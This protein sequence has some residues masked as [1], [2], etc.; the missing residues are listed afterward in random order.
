[1]TSISNQTVT[2]ALYQKQ[3]DLNSQSNEIHSSNTE[4]QQQQD[5]ENIITS[6][7]KTLIVLT[8]KLLFMV[9]IPCLCQATT[10]A[11]LHPVVLVPGSG[12]NQIE[13]RLT[14][15]YKPSSLVCALSALRPKG[16]WFRLWFQPSVIVAPLTQCFAERMMLYY[17]DELDDYH[18]APG[19]ETRVPFFG[20][21]EGL[22]YLDPHLKH[23]TEYMATLVN[24]MERI[25]YESGNNLFGAPYDF[26]YGLAAEG[27]PCHVGNQYLQ[28]LKQLIESAF[29]SNGEKPVIILSHSLGGLFVLQ[30]LNRSPL[31]WRQKY[32]KHFIA[33][34]APWGGAVL[35]MLTFASGYTL[36]IPIVN[37]LIVR[38]EQRSSESNLWLM[39]SPKFFAEKP[40][41]I[42]EKKN[43]SACD[44][45]EFLE[46]IGFGEGVHPYKTRIAPLLYSLEA[47]GVPVT[48][49]VGSGVVT[50]ETLLYG[51]EGFDVQPEIVYGDGDGTVNM[52][53]LLALES[54]WSSQEGQQV[55]NVIKV[56]GVSHMSLLK[57][58]AAVKEIIA[59][60][61]SI[62]SIH[63][64]SVS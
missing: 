63:L 20:S 64:T 56:S 28:D 34:S 1:M 54:E 62:N 10:G 45:Q 55:L 30:L 52:A 11:D 3:S 50:P 24:S 36:G 48:C 51:K 60:V 14:S 59:Q 12:G 42:T 57:N 40:L 17:D 58:E 44:I 39:P 43:Y 5:P 15:E 46:D 47:P 29:N 21:T 23:I 2:H 4:Q 33:V 32:I 26:R 9:A 49:I 37:P 16:S 22:M 31:S 41:V 19:V 8:I 35:Q 61:E 38:G 6:S 27:H 25:G 7:M 18:N 53:S 13:A